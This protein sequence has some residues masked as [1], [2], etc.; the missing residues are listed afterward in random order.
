VAAS[1]QEKA[2][3]TSDIVQCMENAQW[4]EAG[5][6]SGAGGDGASLS[7]HP[8]VRNDP[9]LFTDDVDIRFSRALNSCKVPQI[10]YATP[11]RLLERLTG[12]DY[13]ILF[14]L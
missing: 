13:T 2:A 3:W 9:R 7:V 14:K 4:T 10:R 5:V 1:V 6:G 8:G 12:I 11:S